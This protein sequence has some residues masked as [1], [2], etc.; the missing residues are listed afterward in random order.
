MINYYHCYGG[1]KS[2]LG[3]EDIGRSASS[4]WAGRTSEEVI[5]EE[6]LRSGLFEGRMRRKNIPDQKN[7][8]C[9]GLY[10]GR[11]RRNREEAGELGAG[12]GGI[13]TRRER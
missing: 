4:G 3:E 12:E 13:E 8:T 9:K 6:N 7:R 5:L 10:L 11:S 1:N 2:G